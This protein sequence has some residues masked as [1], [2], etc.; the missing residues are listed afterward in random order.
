MADM[1]PN[2]KEAYQDKLNDAMRKINFNL[3]KPNAVGEH[4]QNVNPS[5][6]NVHMNRV[7]GTMDCDVINDNIST[8]P[9]NETNIINERMLQIL[10]KK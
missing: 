4:K 6:K 9:S 1:L 8:N 7:D 10:S 3:I 2:L 5:N